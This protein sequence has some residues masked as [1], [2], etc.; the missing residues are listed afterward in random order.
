MRLL[1]KKNGFQVEKDEIN[2]KRREE[3]I[4]YFPLIRH[5]PN[6]ERRLQQLFVSAGTSLPSR[7]LETVGGV[8]I[9]THRRMGG[10]Y[11]VRS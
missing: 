5:G 10:I 9:Q 1:P 3:L 6:R 11:E 4:A 7:C 2:K 8:H